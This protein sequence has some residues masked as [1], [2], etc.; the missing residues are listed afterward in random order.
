MADIWTED[1]RNLEVSIQVEKA[2]DD[3]KQDEDMLSQVCF[4]QPA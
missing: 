3:E 1:R 2:Q 4:S